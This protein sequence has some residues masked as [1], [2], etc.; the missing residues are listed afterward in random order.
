[1]ITQKIFTIELFSYQISCKWLTGHLQ[2]F[3]GS[4][5]VIIHIESVSKKLQMAQHCFKK[6]FDFCNIKP[7]CWLKHCSKIKPLWFYCIGVATKICFHNK[8]Q[9]DFKEAHSLQHVFCNDTEYDD[10]V[11]RKSILVWRKFALIWREVIIAT[12]E[13]MDVEIKWWKPV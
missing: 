9:Y 4:C 12:T 11:W 3:S 5:I 13:N 2:H 10:N 8:I 6:T 7:C 1:M